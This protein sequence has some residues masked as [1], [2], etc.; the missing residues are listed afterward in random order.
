MS[1]YEPNGFSDFSMG[2]VL[3]NDITGTFSPLFMLEAFFS[4]T[5]N[6]LVFGKGSLK[7]ENYFKVA[8]GVKRFGKAL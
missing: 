2:G 8:F 7:P 3:T 1:A 5:A 6:E 4:L